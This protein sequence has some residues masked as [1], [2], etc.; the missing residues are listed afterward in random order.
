MVA[1]YP[2]SFMRRSLA[3]LVVLVVVGSIVAV[4][5]A[6]VPPAQLILLQNT[7]PKNATDAAATAT[8]AIDVTVNGS[9]TIAQRVVRAVRVAGPRFLS[10]HPPPLPL[11]H[12][13][14]SH[15]YTQH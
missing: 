2:D 12:M 5:A 13:P 9:A 7:A 15:T 1:C 10:R 8:I 6:T 4:T 11:P 14:L 3:A